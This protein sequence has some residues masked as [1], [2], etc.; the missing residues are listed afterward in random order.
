M[1]CWVH[2]WTACMVW[3]ARAVS[4]FPHPSTVRCAC[5]LMC[6]TGRTACVVWTVRAVLAFPPPSTVRCACELMCY[7]ADRL[8]G[9]DCE[10]RIGIPPSLHCQVCM[11]VNVCYRADRLCGMDCEGRIGIPPSL[12]CQVCMW[13]N[14]LQGGPPVWYGLRGP[15]RHSPLPPLPGVHVYVPP[16]VCRVWQDA[17]RRRLHLSGELYG[18]VLLVIL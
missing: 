3:T 2:V 11:W 10:G 5:E 1:W 14:V 13:V 8:C 7:R 12:H 4:A 6:V 18:A 9:M 17:A 16:G 15:Y